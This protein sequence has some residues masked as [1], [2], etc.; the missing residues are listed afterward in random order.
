MNFKAGNCLFVTILFLLFI[1]L[2]APACGNLGED[3]SKAIK[4]TSE[5]TT[6]NGDVASVNGAVISRTQFENALGYQQEIAAIRGVSI[7]DEQLPELKYQV[8]ENLINQELLY[9]ES[10]RYGIIVEEKDVDDAYGENK[11]KAN[12]ETDAEFEEALKQSNKSMASY[13]EEIKRGLAIDRF[14]QYKFTDQTI[15]QDEEA[16][17]YYDG[18]PALFEQPAQVRVSHIMVRVIPDADQS[19]I[20]AARTKIEKVLEQLKEGEDFESVSREVS[21]DVNSKDNGGDLGYFSKGQT[22]QAF[23]EAAFA[24][25]KDELSD[26]VETDSGYHIIKLTDR[27]EAG[28]VSYEEAKTEIMDSLKTSRV[29]SS[30]DGYI[31][32]LKIRST[33]VTYPI[34]E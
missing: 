28:T 18:N 9:Q 23:E 34:G 13:R 3:E 11:Q 26:I 15:V 29:N 32:E 8:L 31:K 22:P 17:S 1:G 25:K 19:K 30:V 24:L 16:K 7:A 14:I 6:S 10:Q 33:I 21:E 4:A 27:K 20:D 2:G 12:F 5:S